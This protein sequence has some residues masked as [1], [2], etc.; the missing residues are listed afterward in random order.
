MNLRRSYW[1]LLSGFALL[2][3]A[4]AYAGHDSDLFLYAGVLLGLDVLMFNSTKGDE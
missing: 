4:V 3:M 2:I 1:A